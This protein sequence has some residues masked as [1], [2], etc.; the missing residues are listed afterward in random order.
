MNTV[1]M[2]R[3]VE[4]RVSDGLMEHLFP[5]ATHFHT[6]REWR[7]CDCSFCETKRKATRDIAIIEYPRDF[8]FSTIRSTRGYELSQGEKKEIRRAALRKHYRTK[9]KEVYND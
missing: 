9:L 7:D 4:R 1:E 5:K 8:D 6:L 2:F 3:E